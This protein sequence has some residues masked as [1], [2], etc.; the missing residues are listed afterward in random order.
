MTVLNGPIAVFAFKNIYLLTQNPRLAIKLCSKSVM[1]TCLFH[2]LAS[3]IDFESVVCFQ[4][5][6]LIV[7]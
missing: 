6:I 3:F 5:P 7:F 4:L 2:V 1:I